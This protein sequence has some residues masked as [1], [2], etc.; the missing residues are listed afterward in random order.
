MLSIT[1]CQMERTMRMGVFVLTEPTE[2]NMRTANGQV[3]NK[4]Q[5]ATMTLALYSEHLTARYL[6]A[7]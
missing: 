4:L 2:V 3:T 1:R 5:M 6:D 7:S